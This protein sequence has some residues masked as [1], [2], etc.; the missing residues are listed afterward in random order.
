MRRELSLDVARFVER[1]RVPARNQEVILSAFEE[2]GW[3]EQIDDPMPVRGGF[4]PKTRLHHAIN[5]LNRAQENAL[6][7][8]HGNGRGTGIFWKF[9]RPVELR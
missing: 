5:R 6:L 9:R 7:C 8:F 3:P 1:F 2:D 4:D